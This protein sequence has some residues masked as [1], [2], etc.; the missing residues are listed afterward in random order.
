MAEILWIEDDAEFQRLLT[1][2][3]KKAGHSVTECPDRQTAMEIIRAAP[4]K[5]DIVIT[6]I[7]LTNEDPNGGREL[8]KQ[9]N[10]WKTKRGYDP[11][12]LV[13]CITNYYVDAKTQLEVEQ[14]G[15]RYVS[16]DTNVSEYLRN[17]DLLILELEK[18]REQG[19]LFKIVHKYAPE[20]GDRGC[21]VGEEVA[22]V[23]LLYRNSVFPLGLRETPRRIFDY[24]A[25][26]AYTHPQ[27]AIQ[28]VKGLTEGNVFYHEWFA[29]K[30]VSPN[31]IKMNVRRIREALGETF[32]QAHLNLD[33]KIVL[34][35]HTRASEQEEEGDGYE[36]DVEAPDDAASAE[37]DAP[38]AYKLAARISLVHED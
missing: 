3:L 5:F 27:T 15:G 26:Y 18:L 6:D 23:E 1:R 29:G 21:Y 7:H 4:W 31:S 37:R 14:E 13:L 10:E 22:S 38:K 36:D 16:K 33:P 34:V 35:S 20:A 2:K 9:I 25:R 28:I 8:M 24:L 11:A 19:P 12:P 17:V 32:Q 30:S